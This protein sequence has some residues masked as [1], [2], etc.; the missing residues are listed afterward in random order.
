[1]EQAVIDTGTM[2]VVYV[3]REAGV[4]EGVAV[5]LGQRVGGYY[6]VL[7]GL[8]SGDRVAAA[9]SFLLDAETRLNPGAASA[10]FGASG[11]PSGE[12]AGGSATSISPGN[13]SNS[14]A[15]KLST[16]DLENIA[17]LPV[18]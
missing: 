13:S 7:S 9:G 10:Y 3:E 15:K 5:E 8:S 16:A 2:K 12:V 17:Q 11:G 4:F 6:P 1:P 18:E 14:K